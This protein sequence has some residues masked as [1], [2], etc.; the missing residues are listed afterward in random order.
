MVRQFYY[1]NNRELTEHFACNGSMFICIESFLRQKPTP[2]KVEAIEPS[3]VYGIPYHPLEELSK[4]Y[5]E[6][7]SS[8]GECWR[9]R[10]FSGKSRL[11][12]L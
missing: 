7:G 1:K 11:H 4:E 9:D 5:Y 12:P 10:L 6:I 2:L 8:I 3:V